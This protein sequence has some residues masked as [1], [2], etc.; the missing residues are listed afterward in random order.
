MREGR[1]DAIEEVTHAKWLDQIAN[2]LGVYRAFPS[3]LIGID[4]DHAGRNGEAG[5]NQSVVKS[6][7]VIP[8]NC[9]SAIKHEDMELIGIQEVLAA[10][11]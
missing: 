10:R 9:V 4:G 7:P 6:S 3:A 2:N 8:G 5:G 11:E 1:T